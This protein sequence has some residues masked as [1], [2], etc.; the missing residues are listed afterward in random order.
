MLRSLNEMINYQLSATNGEIGKCKDFLF[1]DEH[2]TIRY[3]VADTGRWLLGRKVLISPISIGEPD[4]RYQRFPVNLTKE[5]IENSPA[6]D[7]HA[8][9]S[10]QYER[11]YNNYYY[12]PYYW[13][14]EYAWGPGPYP[15]PT[16]AFRMAEPVKDLEDE[17]NPEENHLRSV[18][19]VDGYHIQASDG[20]I[21][22]V[23]DYIVQDKTWTIRYMVV[24]TRNWLPGRKVLVAP[25]WIESVDWVN[26]KV[27]VNLSTK[28]IKNS[29]EYDPS[30]P[31][32]REYETRLY[33]FY[34]RPVYW[35]ENR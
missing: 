31:V 25:K 6:L 28:E 7:E 1:D 32:N 18:K 16:P 22:H 15:P 5:Q 26:R 35:E 2:W 23:E 11:K 14:G 17:E 3:M 8:P 19:E 24:D 27:E 20:D 30:L 12:W 29:P 10:R 34:G 33:D 4:W 13:G 9:V 21:G